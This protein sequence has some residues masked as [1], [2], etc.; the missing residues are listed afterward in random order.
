MILPSR[1]ANYLAATCLFLASSVA[2]A[3]DGFSVVGSKIYDP[4]GRE[5]IAKGVNING[6]RWVWPGNM[7][8]S[9]HVTRIV[10]GFKFN[11]VR[12]PVSFEA[13][14]WDDNTVEGLVE[15]YTSRG[16]VVM[17]DAH[18]KIGGYFEGTELD[19]LKDFFRDLA[20]KYKNN[21]YVWFNVQNEP[22][23]TTLN[24]EKWLKV[25]QE[26]IRV[27][28]D[29]AGANNI[30]VCDG[31]AWGQDVG[32]WTS[33]DVRPEKSAILSYGRELLQFGGKSYSNVIF[34]VHAYDQWSQ[35]S[36]PQ[37]RSKMEN[38]I[39]RVHAQGLALI[40]GEYGVENVNQDTWPGTQGAIAAAQSQ[41]V[42]RFVWAWWGG[43]DNELTTG[44]NGGGQ[45]LNNLTNPTNLSRL[46]QLV[47]DDN[48]RREDLEMRGGTPPPQPTPTR[49]PTVTPSPRPTTPP[50]STPQPTPR[51]TAV[52]TP[53]TAPSHYEAEVA[54]ISGCRVE[55]KWSGYSGSGYV[56]WIRPSGESIEWSVN[57]SSEREVELS[58]KYANGGKYARPLLV[59]VNGRRTQT[60]SFSPSG[61][62]SNWKETKIGRKIKLKAGTNKVKLVSTGKS[63][64]NV[65]LLKIR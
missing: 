22:G 50:Q 42:G 46:G 5:F 49:S 29:E 7:T 14:Q 47:W 8:T 63:G 51:P 4:S 28:R 19:T 17:F 11:A 45:Y 3:Q 64:A 23:G 43:D 40:I 54:K 25:H 39:Q 58:F 21:P 57:S 60:L 32:E 27:V 16:L 61:G 15:T 26:V 53:S 6:I 20:I 55:D 31:A 62:W 35:G 12:V 38:F 44:G 48:R 65:D 33:G 30:I 10:D 37:N 36:V 34:S 56:D 18:D 41:E 9:E 52:A 1:L 13:S 59:E 2:H 24:R